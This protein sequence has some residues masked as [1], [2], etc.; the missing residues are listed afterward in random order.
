M[1]KNLVIVESPAKAKT[2]EGFLGD[3]YVVTSSMG[4]VRDLEKKDFGIDIENNYQPRYKV[5][6]DKKKIVTELKK[7]AK[8][9]ET[10]WLA[11]DEDREGEAIAWHLKEVLK[12]KDDKIKRIVFHE[13]T[14]DA[15]TRAVENPRDIDQHL[16]NAQQARRVL[17]RI[18]GFEVS[19]VLWKKVKPSLSAGRVQSVAVRL[20][21]ER[22]RE[23]RN[24]NSETWF[25]VNGYFLVSDEKGN[26][27]E[28]KAE[29][30][31][32]FKTRDEANDFLEKCKTADFKV[33]DVVKKPGKRS[34]AQPFTTSTLQQEASRKLGF[35]V[36]QTM[37]VAQR[38]YES[39]KITYMRTD[40]V[41]LSGL[42][43][44]TSK[45]KITELH[46]E[47]YVKIR[48]FKNKSKGAQEAHEAI[49]PTYME[50]QTVDGSSQEQ[51]LYELIWKRTIA[52]Q[53]ADAI[54]ERT[55]VTI[56]VSNATEKFQATGE[57]IVFDG[58]LKVYIESTDDENTN[59]SGQSLIPPVH[60]NDP[61]EMTSVISTQRFSQRPPRFTEASLVKR[62][63]ELGIGR[64]STY[65]PTITTVQNRNYVVKE[66]RPGVE[67]NYNVLT[68][69]DGKIKEE[70]KTEIT[71]AEKNKLFPTDIGI[72]VNDFLMDNFDEIMDYN[73]TANVEKEFDDIA[74]GKRVW[75]EMIDK[76]YQPFHGKVEHALEN[77]ERSK[78]ERILGVD[79][80]TGKQ[81][82]VKI[83]RYGP[84]A[85]LG[86][87]SQEEDTEKPQFSSLR[88][89]QHIET[90]TLE[91]ALD[92]FKLPRELGEYE[93][94]KVTVAIGRFGPYVR[95]DNKF[96]SLGK[97]DDPYSVKLDRAI[98]LI[99]AKREKDRKAVIKIFDEDAELQVLNG[100]W[101]PYIKHKKKNYKIPK[102]TKAEE[103]TYDDCIKI[104]ESAPEPKNRRGR[105]K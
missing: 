47:N 56:D 37:A 59:G 89:G 4:H 36:S 76:F 23:I 74:D 9:A 92:L 82:S 7:L 13:I 90:I 21:V 27:T 19:P 51:R 64:P 29:L 77:A 24:F 73:F 16:V 63:E 66:E 58:F 39:G 75:N 41:N 5:S 30:S 101:G 99:E 3:G 52:S 6:S 96:V 80:K 18:V 42:A 87:T 84:L 2:I 85:Q 69:K 1:H 15:I 14:K 50:N 93:D 31:K 34:P 72:V 102:T 86:E 81:V 45:Q 54:L 57:V 67:R 46:G 32:R 12:L 71:G 40:S 26:T 78:G 105:K 98:E 20:I 79:P 8:E 60:V 68:L 97:E 62:L 70:E 49:R 38:L 88:T 61:L 103:L 94:K 83:G 100:R 104:I 95:H 17:D 11:S 43:I 53:M 25:R 91:E 65:A 48:K 28:L 44:N 55:N 22:E 10:V 33:S 35:S